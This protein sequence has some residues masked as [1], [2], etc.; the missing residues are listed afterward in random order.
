[1]FCNYNY[2]TDK[3]TRKSVGGLVATLGGK[4]LTCLSKTQRTVTLRSTEADYLALSACA[5]EVKFG[6]MLPG[7][8]IEVEIL[9][10]FMRITK[11]LFF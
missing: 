10:L 9:L 11:A 3:Y 7:K 5:K 8:I 4:L 2:A 6:I 1:M